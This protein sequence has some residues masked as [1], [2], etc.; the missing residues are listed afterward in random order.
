MGRVRETLPHGCEWVMHSAGSLDG[1]WVLQLCR[2]LVSR[3][4]SAEKP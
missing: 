1:S 4:P 3:P 2:D